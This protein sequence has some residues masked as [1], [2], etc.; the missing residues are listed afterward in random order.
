[1]PPVRFVIGGEPGALEH[2]CGDRGP[3][4]AAAHHDQRSIAR[5]VA[6]PLGQVPTHDV[7]CPWQMTLAPLVVRSDIQHLRTVAPCELAL[8][9]SGSDLRRAG[10]R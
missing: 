3:I 9:F 4:A 2:T 1:M 6:D 8:Q 5:D 7:Q 10:D